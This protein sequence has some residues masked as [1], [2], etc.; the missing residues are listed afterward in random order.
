MCAHI[1]N[2]AACASPCTHHAAASTCVPSP[3]TTTT[4]APAQTRRRA[5]GSAGLALSVGGVAS[6]SPHPARHP[7]PPRHIASAAHHGPHTAATPPMPPMGS[8]TLGQGVARAGLHPLTHTPSVPLAHA[9]FFVH[10]KFVGVCVFTSHSDQPRNTTPVGRENLCVTSWI[11]SV[12][13]REG[14]ATPL[15]KHP[16]R[17]A[18]VLM[19]PACVA[20]A[21]SCSALRY[22]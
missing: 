1:P 21:A 12:H 6:G 22:E 16:T 9:N 20:A 19:C 7:S 15:R 13:V 17:R 11:A 14:R 18:V 3:V 5:R 10:R 8:L 2:L 4:Q